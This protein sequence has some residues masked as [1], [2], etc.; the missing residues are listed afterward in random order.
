MSLRYVLFRENSSSHEEEYL[1]RVGNGGSTFWTDFAVVSEP[2]NS[3]LQFDTAAE[4]Y[5]FAEPYINL[6]F[7]RVGLR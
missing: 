3:N 1:T 6:Q 4:G 2:A 7:W 5:E